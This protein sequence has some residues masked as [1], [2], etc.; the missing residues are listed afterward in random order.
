MRTRQYILEAAERMLQSKGLARLTNK[1]IAQ[2]A[3]CAE[4]T[5]YKHFETK[6]ELILSAIE[7]H[8]PDFLA[9]VQDDRIGYGSLEANVQDIAHAAIRYYRKLVPLATSLFADMELMARFRHW[10][11]EQQ[12]GPLNLYEKVADYLAAEQQIGRLNQAIQPF[13]VAALLLGACFQY[14]FVQYFQGQDPFPVSEQVYVAGLVQTLL[15]GGAP[16]G[17]HQSSDL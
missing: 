13:N 12:A 4:G 17:K 7:E 14:V 11:Q 6:E 2:E 3:G 15:M 1:E 8:L 10:M 16:Q 9:V 5:L